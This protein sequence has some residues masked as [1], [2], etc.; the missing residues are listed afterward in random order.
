MCRSRHLAR[1]ETGW[2]R[3]PARLLLREL[4]QLAL[5]R[6]EVALGGVERR[7]GLVELEQLERSKL[8][9]AGNH[10]VLRSEPALPVRDARMHG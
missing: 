7:L 6:G 5:L 4:S 3:G 9:E 8:R 10:L 1:A 2:C